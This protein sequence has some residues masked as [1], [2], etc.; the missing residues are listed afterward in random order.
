M[1]TKATRKWT[2]L[3][4]HSPATEWRFLRV[5]RFVR[6]PPRLVQEPFA[7]YG[8]LE[9]FLVVGEV[10]GDVVRFERRR[11]LEGAAALVALKLSNHVKEMNM[12]NGH[13]A[14][15]NQEPYRSR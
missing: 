4:T 9:R 3:L 5:Y 1:S 15:I 14:K 8:A 10:D 13:R 2:K 7:A 12:L 11:V 6:L